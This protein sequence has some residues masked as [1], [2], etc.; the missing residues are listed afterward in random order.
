MSV[1]CTYTEHFGE[2][3]VKI[4]LVYYGLFLNSGEVPRGGN[5]RGKC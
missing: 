3:L 2:F 5:R 4:I 1:M